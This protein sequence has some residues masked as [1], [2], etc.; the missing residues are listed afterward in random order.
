MKRNEKAGSQAFEGLFRQTA[1]LIGL[2]LRNCLG[3][4]EVI[5][6]KDGRKVSVGIS[7]RVGA[8]SLHCLRRAQPL[9]LQS[10]Q[11]TGCAKI[12]K[13]D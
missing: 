6:G 2:K 12:R 3:I 5:H 11:Q 10:G 9:R 13:T 4:N 7:Q 8:V 1:L